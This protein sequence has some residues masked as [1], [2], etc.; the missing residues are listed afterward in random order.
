MKKRVGVIPGDGIGVEVIGEAVKV[1]EAASQAF[2]FELELTHFDWGAE[3][4]LRDG[5]TLP[6]GAVEMFQTEY[7]AILTGAFGD[8]RV[9]DN[10]HAHDILL[11]LR[12]RLDLYVNLRPVKLLNETL[13]P[14][15]GRTTKD[16]DFV[17]FRENTEGAYVNVGGVFKKGTRDEIAVQEEIHTRQ[18]VERII[19]VAFDYA[20]EHKRERVTLVDKAN[21]M[22]YGHD[23]WQR[24]FFE[25]ATSYPEIETSHQYVDA[26]ALL[27]VLN[28]NEWQVIVTNNM[29][30]DI[31]SD[32]GAALTGGLGLAP[33]GNIHPGRVSLFEPVHGTAPA[34]AGKNVAN[35]IGA[36]LTTSMMLDYLGY[37]QAARAI[38]AAVAEAIQ[39]GAVTQDLGG[40]LSTTEVGDAVAVR[41][42]DG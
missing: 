16:I 1:I 26:M 41:V 8:A 39:A 27:M 14:L 35:P 34:L 4:Y 36:I 30:G 7:D 6:E 21:V 29:F 18:G 40:S 38:E 31:L 2:G 17:I 23:L 32:L 9:K 20:R 11:G 24:T 3:K 28:P 12:F 5:I 15:K 42:R 13:T 33:S 22:R 37:R 25:I 10:N 19:R